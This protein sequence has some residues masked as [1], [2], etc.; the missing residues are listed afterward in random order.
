MT[1]KK[2]S[3]LE[4]LS[5]STCSKQ[6]SWGSSTE[7]VHAGGQRSYAERSL[8]LPTFGT[9]TYIFK[10]TNDLVEFKEGEQKNKG[11]MYDYGRYGNPSVQVCEQRVA[12]LDGGEEAVLFSSGMGAISAV[13]LGLLKSGDHMVIG[14]E[15]YRKTR[16]LCS[17]ILKGFGISVSVVPMGDYEALEKAINAKT[18]LIFSESPTNPYLRVVD[19]EKLSAIARRHD[20]ITAIDSTFA[21]PINQRPLEFGIDIVIH[22]ATKYLSGNNDILAGAVVGSSDILQVVRDFRGTVGGIPSAEVAVR[23]EQSLKTLALRVLQQNK[24][25]Q[26]VAEFL[27]Q[28]PLIEKVWYPGLSSHPDAQ[29]AAEQM[30]GFGGV[31][32]FEMKGSGIDASLLIDAVKIP[33]IAASLG[34]VESLIEQPSIISFFHMTP[35]ERLKIG[36]KDTLIRFALGIEDTEDLIDDLEQA[37]ECVFLRRRDRSFA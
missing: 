11:L 4:L 15:C 25:A 22:S 27:E 3:R 7:S 35:E 34:G 31:V 23:L 19:L 37:L 9:A 18:R 29:I 30:S 24:N 33:K 8:T 13:L 6:P 1:E 17:D 36:I 5:D 14:E 12:Q 21:T 2:E 10:N 16:C 20:L 28:H 26:R 32:S